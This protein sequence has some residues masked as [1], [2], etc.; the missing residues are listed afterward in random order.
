MERM[1]KEQQRFQAAVAAMQGMLA[2]ANTMAHETMGC[3]LARS[4]IEHADVL[5]AELDGTQAKDNPPIQTYGGWLP[6]P[7]CGKPTLNR[8]EAGALELDRAASK[9]EPQPE[10]EEWFSTG[11]TV[12]TKHRTHLFRAENPAEAK[13]AVDAHNASLRIATID[14]LTVQPNDDGWHRHIPGDSM[15]DIKAG[16]IEIMTRDGSLNS[17]NPKYFDFGIS[18]GDDS[19]EIVAWRVVE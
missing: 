14:S 12:H 9:D 16:R 5:L 6:C 13:E 10:M 1:N 18:F 2:N 7:T 8:I 17:G 19:D 4:A 15:P 11:R 3:S